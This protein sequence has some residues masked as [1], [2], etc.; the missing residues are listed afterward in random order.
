MQV[1]VAEEPKFMPKRGGYVAAIDI[2]LRMEIHNDD[3]GIALD[4]LTCRILGVETEIPGI[5][6]KIAL[7]LNEFPDELLILSN[8]DTRGLCD[9]FGTYETGLWEGEDVMISIEERE[10]DGTP[11][12][13]M[14]VV[15]IEVGY[16]NEEEQDAQD[17]E[18]L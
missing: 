14:S 1:A 12:W 2:S 8:G 13:G 4:F 3:T 5:P 9:A 18:A 10:F 6:N 16:T 17:Y 15:G 11:V 7:S